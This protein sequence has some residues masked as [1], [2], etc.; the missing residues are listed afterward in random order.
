MWFEKQMEQA[1]LL[2]CDGTIIGQKII[3]LEIWKIL[4]ILGSACVDCAKWVITFIKTVY[5][6]W[7]EYQID[8]SNGQL[9][10]EY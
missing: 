10:C 8:D 4:R 7:L 3:S 9:L 1:D 2:Q 6:T 5:I